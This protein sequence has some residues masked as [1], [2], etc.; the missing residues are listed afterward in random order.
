MSKQTKKKEKT[1]QK[2]CKGKRGKQSEDGRNVTDFI[3]RSEAIQEQTV[4][5]D[6]Q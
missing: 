3:E 6:V 2:E 1:E 4:L 5:H